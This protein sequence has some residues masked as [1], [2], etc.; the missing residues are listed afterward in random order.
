VNERLSAVDATYLAAEEP[1]AP[2]HVGSIAVFEGAPLLD[3]RGALRLDELRRRID[4]RLGLLPRLRQRIA[5]VPFD[6]ARPV[7]VDDDDFDIAN[8]VDVVTLPAPHDQRALLRL[9]EELLMEKLDRTRPLW[10]LRFVTGLAD[11]NVALIQRAHHAMV[12]GVSGVDV[13]LVL[14]D[15]APDSPA[16]E[17]DGWQ[18]RRAPTAP[19]LLVSGVIDRIRAPLSLSIRAVASLRR[20]D[21]VARGVAD[22]VSA[23]RAVGSDGVRAPHTS[24][25]VPIGMTRRIT[26][27]RERLDAVRAAGVPAGA[28]VNDVVLTAVAGGLRDLFLGRG[29]EMPTTRTV[30]ALVPVSLRGSSESMALGNR[31]GALVV[32]LPVGLIDADDRLAAVVAATRALKAS[33]EATTTDVLLHAAD[34]L[35]QVVARLIQRGVHHQ[36]IVNVVVTNVPGPPFPLYALGAR[37]LDAIPVV[38]LGGNM[39]LEVAILSYDG[40]LTLSVTSDRASCPDVDVFVDGVAAAFKALSVEHARPNTLPA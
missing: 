25:N 9:A 36:P 37:M 7:W 13:S 31:V 19:E 39:S 26:V 22:V 20:P 3:E 33:T 14:L 16:T 32:S 34:L 30:R 15:A 5:V 23:L 28:T 21:E 1:R 4:A 17:A 2:L 40:A 29:E 38:P 27:V 12:D 35:P 24:L 18:P 10:H 11:G 6:V 8:H